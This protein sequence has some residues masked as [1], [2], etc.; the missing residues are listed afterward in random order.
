M[1]A[2]EPRTVEQIA[3]DYDLPLQAVREAIIYCQNNP[4][5]IREDWEREEDASKARAASYRKPAPRK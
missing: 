3:A 2:E 1:S 4:S 5:E